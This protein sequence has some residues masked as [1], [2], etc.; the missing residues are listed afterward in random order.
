MKK[1]WP[2]VIILIFL[3]TL[4]YFVSQVSFNK[5]TN[6]A[7][8]IV[9]RQAEC[10]N[11]N[12]WEQYLAI[13]KHR[14]LGVGSKEIIPDH[15]KIIDNIKILW[16]RKSKKKITMK[17]V[18]DSIGIHKV[19]VYDAKVF[20]VVYYLTNENGAK[21]MIAE[22]GRKILVEEVLIVKETKESPWLYS[23]LGDY[24]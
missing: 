12:D 10:I 1:R 16:M 8:K 4:I 5:G 3:L 17:L 18:Y 13:T 6:E 9:K 22:N 23:L 7:K 21:S 15:V 11:N 14:P 20:N 24:E 19:P 2:F